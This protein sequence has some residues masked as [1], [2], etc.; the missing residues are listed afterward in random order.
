MILQ[1]G[2]SLTGIAGYREHHILG[3]IILL[4]LKDANMSGIYKLQMD[5]FPITYSARAKIIAL[6]LY[7]EMYL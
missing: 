6:Q 1:R 3:F 4:L 7:S 2:P 5:H